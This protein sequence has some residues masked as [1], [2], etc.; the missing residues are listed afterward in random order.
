MHCR[1]EGCKQQQCK[2]QQ[3]CKQQRLHFLEQ[4]QRREK[5]DQQHVRRLHCRVEGC[6]QQL[7]QCKQQQR[8]TAATVCAPFRAGADA[9]K[10]WAAAR[11]AIALQGRGV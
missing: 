11:A 6:K 7:Q 8:N 3:K 2:Q 1:G 4:M 10:G 9:G 5:A